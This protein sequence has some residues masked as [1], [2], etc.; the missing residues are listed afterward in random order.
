MRRIAKNIL[1]GSL[2]ILGVVVALRG[3]ALLVPSGSWVAEGRMASARSSAAAALLS[4]GRILVT[5]GDMG[6]GPVASA[7]F[8]NVDGTISAAPPMIFARSKH[9]ALVLQDGRILVAGGITAGG[10]STSSAE[11]FDSVAN[12]WTNVGAG[13]T[14]ARSSATAVVLQDGR[15]LIAGGQNGTSISSTIEIFDPTLGTFTPAGMMS[16]PRTQHAMA[17]LENGR[18]IIVGGNS[19]TAPV[20]STDVFDPVAGTVSA[21]PSLAIARFG[22]SATT[23]LNGQVVVIGGNNGNAIPSQMDVTPSELFDPTAGTFTTLATN[24]VTQREGHLAILLPNNNN[25]LIVGGTSG[26]TT[27]DSAELFSQ[28]QGTFTNAY[29]YDAASNRTGF[30]APESSTNTYS[31]DTLNRLTHAGNSRRGRSG[32]AT[33]R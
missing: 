11:I 13:M 16:S 8:I 24:L 22:H 20:A 19:G 30:T 27:L 28:W 15:V 3:A 9:V 2:L 21:G 23:L 10:S 7:D 17:A 12:S 18:V 25:I 26:G 4:D 1:L 14:E 6:T 32:S 33:T 5:G 31:Y 29:T